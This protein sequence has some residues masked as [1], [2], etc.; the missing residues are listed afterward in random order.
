MNSERKF[1]EKIYNENARKIKAVCFR[2][3][4]DK[5]LAE[6]LMHDTFVTAINKHQGFQERGVI[7]AWLRKIAV[8]TSLMHLRSQKKLLELSHEIGNYDESFES[9][10]S[11]S[12]D[13]ISN[14]DFSEQ[15]LLEMINQLPIHHKL[16]FNLYAFE[17]F[18]HMEIGNELNI[19]PGTSKSHLA[20]ARKKLQ[21]LLTENASKKKLKRASA[22]IPFLAAGNQFVDSIF[23][24]H[25][26]ESSLET[27]SN[28]AS[29]TKSVIWK[30]SFVFLGKSVIV[31]VKAL[32]ISGS[33]AL[34]VGGGTTYFIL[35]NSNQ[36]ANSPKTEITSPVIST[37]QQQNDSTTVEKD[38]LNQEI[39]STKHP[40]QAEAEEYDEDT[41]IKRTLIIHKPIVIEKDTVKT[42]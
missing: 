41:I 7:E 22:I 11:E 3:T 6:D 23:K 4:G 24:N 10:D 27:T 36:Q 29:I 38:T 30:K 15:E 17:K 39:T 40:N 26:A 20:R 18:T 37:T 21:L 13:L 1:W 35:K 8:N 5:E 16:V 19:S 34:L 32:V 14:T 33:A 9:T 42:N 2:Y 25:L 12:E 31:S 28:F